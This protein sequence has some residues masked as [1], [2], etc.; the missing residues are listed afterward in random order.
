MVYEEGGGSQSAR[1]GA[2]R[3]GANLG[4]SFELKGSPSCT[5]G[6][7]EKQEEEREG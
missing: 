3:T 1:N 2:Q 4:I 5:K 6:Y 7:L